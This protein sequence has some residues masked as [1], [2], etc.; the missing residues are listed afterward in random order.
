MQILTTSII[1]GGTGK[2]TTAAALAQAAKLEGK[3]VLAVDLDPQANFTAFLGQEPA[4]G[5]YRLLHGTPAADTIQTTEQGID[6]IAANTDLAAEKTK[7]ASASRLKEGLESIQKKYDLI[8]IDTPPAI[9]ELTYNALMASTG[10]VIP[11]ETDTNNIQGLYYI[12]DVAAEIATS[13]EN[14]KISGVILTKYD[15]RSNFNREVQE[16]VIE[17]CKEM[18]VRYLGE[19]RNGIAIREA[20]GYQQSLFEYAPKSK[21][22]LDYME[23]YKKIIKSRKR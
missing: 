16:L 18:G 17:K 8:I 14:L 19:V 22:A 2:S 10:L 13:N 7:P 15:S 5:C 12:A 23:I 11:L 3:K 6:L 1:K 4:D 9:G 21:P 20:Q